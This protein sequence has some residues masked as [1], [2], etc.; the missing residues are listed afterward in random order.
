M[1]TNGVKTSRVILISAACLC[2]DGLA[3]GATRTVANT[4]VSIL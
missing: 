1:A 4:R 2:S 3:S